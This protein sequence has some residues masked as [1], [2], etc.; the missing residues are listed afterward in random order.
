MSR[1]RLCQTCGV[2]P[3]AMKWFR[4]CYDCKPG[5]PFQ[6]PPC[7]DC[8]SVEGYFTAGLCDWCHRDTWRRAESC[9]DCLAWGVTHTHQWSCRACLAWRQLNPTTGACGVCRD[10]RHLGRGGFCRLCWCTAVA[11]HRPIRRTGRTYHPQ[12]IAAGNRHGQQLFLA[13][14]ARA[15]RYRLPATIAKSTQDSKSTPATSTSVHRRGPRHG[16]LALFD[17]QPP[18]W[19][20]RHGLRQPRDHRTAERLHALTAVVAAQHGWNSTTVKNTR[21]VLKVL[22]ALQQPSQPQP[23]TDQAPSGQA[24]ADQ[25]DAD[26]A[27]ADHADA[28]QRPGGAILA[29]DL[30]RLPALGLTGV[31]PAR[32]VLIAA[33]LFQDDSTPAL[34]R[35]F[36]RTVTDLPEPMRAEVSAWFAVLRHGSSSPPRSRPRDEK[37]IRVRVR[38]AL[39][40]LRAWAEAGHTSLREITRGHV[41]SVLPPSGSPRAVT[42]AALRSLFTTLKVHRTLFTN[43]IAGVRTGAPER[44]QPLPVAP[45][46]LNRTLHSLDPPTAALA[47]LLAFHGLRPGELRHLQLTDLRHGRLHLDGRVIPLAAPVRE[48]LRTYLDHRGRRWPRTANLHLFIHQGTAGQTVAVGPRWLGLRLGMPAKYLREDRILD[49][50]HATGGDVRR[51]SDLFG[52]AVLTATRYTATVDHPDLTRTNPARTDP[53]RSDP[54]STP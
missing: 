16:Q 54:R 13:N 38:Y 15:L 23:D 21:L 11:V 52:I 14:T 33:G 2:K 3:V 35:W 8:G 53:A 41:V 18:D 29:S 46:D 32:T 9:R 20:S 1:P 31:R 39:P 26:H 25:A 51:L 7:R 44:R 34:E 24:D 22:L 6:A 30:A 42:G 45:A 36:A 37:T 10:V 47:A 12:D 49:E 19:L 40:A 48:R 43:P 27:D 5:G 17:N 28:Q 4:H 50:A